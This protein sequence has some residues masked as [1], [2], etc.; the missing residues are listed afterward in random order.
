MILALRAK[1]LAIKNNTHF[2][3]SPLAFPRSGTMQCLNVVD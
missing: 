3:T 2:D 1:E